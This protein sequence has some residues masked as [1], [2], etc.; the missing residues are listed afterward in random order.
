MDIPPSFNVLR[1]VL[2]LAYIVE[3][4]SLSPIRA[5]CLN[6]YVDINLNCNLNKTN[7]LIVCLTISSDEE[8]NAEVNKSKPEPSDDQA[9]VKTVKNTLNG[10]E[11]I[12]TESTEPPEDNSTLTLG[13]AGQKYLI[14]YFI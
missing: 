9:V 14:L 7:F 2:C 6:K 11:P 10:K 5:E 12:I 13:I 3:R 4:L 1:S 8:D